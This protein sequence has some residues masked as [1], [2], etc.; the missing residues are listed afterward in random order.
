MRDQGGRHEH[1]TNRSSVPVD[2]I[3]LSIA[4][5]IALICFMV[6]FLTWGL[7]VNQTL[8]VGVHVV[9]IHCH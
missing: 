7:V 4:L 6:L 2:F 3:A 8:R 5:S 9:G 1:L